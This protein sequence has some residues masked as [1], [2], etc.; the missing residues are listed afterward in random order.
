MNRG[1]KKIKKRAKLVRSGTNDF[2]LQKAAFPVSPSCTSSAQ[3]KI[4]GEGKVLELAGILNFLGESDKT[5][6]S[7]IESQLEGLRQYAHS[8]S[9]SSSAPIKQSKQC[10]NYGKLSGQHLTACWNCLLDFPK[11]K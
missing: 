10:S 5:L 6:A 8:A 11:D 2:E 9:S 3:A 4:D 1:N 7:N